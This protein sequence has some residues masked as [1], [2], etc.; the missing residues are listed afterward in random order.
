MRRSLA[1]SLLPLVAGVAQAATLTLLPT[2]FTPT[3]ISGDGSAIVGNLAA[4]TQYGLWTEAQGLVAIGGT[5]AGGG[6]G[7][8]ATPNADASR[9]AGSALNPAS[10]WYEASYYTVATGQW[11]Y[12]GGLGGLGPG[13][14][15]TS[16]A[17]AISGDGRY[18]AGMS[19]APGVS[20]G[21]GRATIWDTATGTVTN[22]GPSGYAGE[23]ASTRIN[24]ISDDGRVAVGWGGGRLPMVWSDPTGSGQYTPFQ[25]DPASGILG[26]AAAVTGDGRWVAG[27]GSVA[28]PD[29]WL[30][31]VATGLV[32]LGSL[33]VPRSLGITTAISDDGSIVV[34]AQRPRAGLVKDGVGFIWTAAAGMPSTQW[35][36][37]AS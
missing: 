12:L 29:P 36:A 35:C 5:A 18:V 1:L 24:D 14:G 10:G 28:N 34:G 13:T 2:G 31:S 23:S 8:S 32:D 4:G 21:G 33:P 6:I 7:G 27:L 9:V 17:Y 20:V 16:A 15:E 11:T 37:P 22:L 19:W 3:G 26:E 30:W 25:I